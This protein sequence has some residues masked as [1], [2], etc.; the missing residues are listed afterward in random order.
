MQQIYQGLGNTNFQG[1]EI[2][3]DKYFSFDKNTTL[4]I[5]KTTSMQKEYNKRAIAL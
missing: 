4:T 1:I 3:Q 5:V 2:V